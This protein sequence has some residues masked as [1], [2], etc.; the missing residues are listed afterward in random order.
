MFHSFQPRI[1]PTLTKKY[2]LQQ[3]SLYINLWDFFKILEKK[4]FHE[5]PMYYWYIILLSS[6]N[7]KFIVGCVK[8]SKYR[9]FDFYHQCLRF[10]FTRILDGDRTFWCARVSS[11]CLDLLNYILALNHFTENNMASIKP[12]RL[13]SCDKKLRSVGIGTS[14]CLLKLKQIF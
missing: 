10:K 6:L 3:K 8:N 7:T 4:E 5:S 2:C 9:S 13:H 1:K 11:L 14:I 12:R